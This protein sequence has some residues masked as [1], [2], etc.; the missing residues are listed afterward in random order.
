MGVCDS[1]LQQLDDALTLQPSSSDDPFRSIS[2][3]RRQ[4]LPAATPSVD[5]QAVFAREL[6]LVRLDLQEVKAGVQALQRG[7]STAESRATTPGIMKPKEAATY[8]GVTEATLRNWSKR[9]LKREGQGRVVRY[10]REV[11]DTF[12]QGDKLS[13][14]AVFADMLKGR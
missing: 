11:L 13:V 9:G 3:A 12:M 5:S 7:T 2:L 1:I 14:D 4:P 10:R 6:A 8:C